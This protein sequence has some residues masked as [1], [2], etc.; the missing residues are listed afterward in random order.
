MGVDGSPTFEC[1]LPWPAV[2]SIAKTL[3]QPYVTLSYFK[4]SRLLKKAMMSGHWQLSD[5]EILSEKINQMN[6]RINYFKLNFSD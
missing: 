1:L 3:K 2:T 6:E 4:I 5:R